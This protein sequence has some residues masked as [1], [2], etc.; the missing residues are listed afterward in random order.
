MYLPAWILV[1][2]LRIAKH[3]RTRL[4]DTWTQVQSD[5]ILLFRA[6]LATVIM[7]RFFSRGGEGVGCRYGDL[8]CTPT[9]GY[10][11]YNRTRKGPRDISTERKLLCELPGSAHPDIAEVLKYF[12][13][14]RTKFFSGK[15]PD[16][17]LASSHREP[18]TQ[19]TSETLPTW[20]QLVLRAVHEHP[21]GGFAWTSHSL[22]KGA[23]TTTYGIG[24]PMQKIKVLFGGWARALDVVRDYI[25][26]TT[27]PSLGAW[28]L[29]GLTIPGGAPPIV[30][31]RTATNSICEPQHL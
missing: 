20:L 27:L 10:H 25:D 22:R 3:L 2:S 12:D 1:S 13:I 6:C 11:L 17:I 21:P 31:R 15:L 4:T 29:F 23:T 30:T 18:T 9:S 7:F 14:A 5:T 8:L 19:W 26:P 28:Q 24:T 16:K